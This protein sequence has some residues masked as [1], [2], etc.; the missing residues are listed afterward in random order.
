MLGS[1]AFLL[2][3][4]TTASVAHMMVL[5]ITGCNYTGL[6]LRQT[7]NSDSTLLNFG[8]SMVSACKFP[9][10]ATTQTPVD[11]LLA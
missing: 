5:P 9:P 8:N 3:I 4:A 11:L 1:L 7:S 10:E 6:S 2:R